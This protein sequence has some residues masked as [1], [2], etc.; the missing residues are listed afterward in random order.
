MTTES[1]TE[2]PKTHDWVIDVT[3][4]TSARN[5][6][7]QVY[8]LT[9]D[10][11]LLLSAP[12]CLDCSSAFPPDDLRCTPSEAPDAFKAAVEEILQPVPPRR[13]SA[14]I[15]KLSDAYR[16]KGTGMD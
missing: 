5:I 11:R 3:Y 13:R 9:N 4:R 1:S 8:F 2:K 7:D 16:S 14:R 12:R 10:N 6:D 15:T